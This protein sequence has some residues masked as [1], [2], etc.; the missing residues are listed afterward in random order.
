[1]EI[2]GGS[3]IRLPDEKAK[4]RAIL[5]PCGTKAEVHH[6]RHLALTRVVL[7]FLQRRV[8]LGLHF[9]V[10]Q[11]DTITIMGQP[12]QVEFGDFDGTSEL[13]GYGRRTAYRDLWIAALQKG[14]DAGSLAIRH[15]E[16]VL[17][18][19]GAIEGVYEL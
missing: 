7:D 19:T 14:T 17:V 5:S 9:C 15:L 10:R 2:Y 16:E 8:E 6:E 11:H 12:V 18:E 1:M 3:M 13:Q 4:P